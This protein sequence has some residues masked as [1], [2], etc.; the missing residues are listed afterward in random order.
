MSSNCQLHP[1]RC[2][3]ATFLL[4]S[5]FWEACLWLGN[6]LAYFVDLVL[7]LADALEARLWFS[8]TFPCW[9]GLMC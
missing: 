6:L 8:S 1:D 7:C 4:H 3:F 5:F 2:E 9:R